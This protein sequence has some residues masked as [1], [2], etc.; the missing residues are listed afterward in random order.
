[1]QVLEKPASL[2]AQRL[3]EVKLDGHNLNPGHL[4]SLVSLLKM[5]WRK[6]LWVQQGFVLADRLAVHYRSG[7]LSHEALSSLIGGYKDWLADSKQSK[8]DEE[9]NSSRAAEWPVESAA[10]A[11]Y[12]D[13]LSVPEATR[14]VSLATWDFRIPRDTGYVGAVYF[15]C[16]DPRDSLY[17]LLDLAPD[18]IADLRPDYAATVR[19]TGYSGILQSLSLFILET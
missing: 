13:Q 4:Q 7:N 18:D 19:W 9:I 6:R 1:M 12:S 3:A 11:R 8:I 17:G 16:S 14:A 5:P 15:H 2:P 10:F